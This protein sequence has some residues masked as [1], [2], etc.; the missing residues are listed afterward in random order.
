MNED[1]DGLA[2]LGPLNPTVEFDRIV[3]AA[4]L[5]DES[6]AVN[7][8]ADKRAEMRAGRGPGGRPATVNDRTILI[9]LFLLAAEHN[10][11]HLTR[12]TQMVQ[13]R[14][15]EDSLRYLDLGGFDR[16]SFDKVYHRFARALQ[17]LIEPCD[18]FKGPRGKRLTYAEYETLI[19]SRD[20]EHV[21]RLNA[22]LH[23]IVNDLVMSSVLTYG[24]DVLEGFE[25]NYAVDGTFVKSGGR[26]GTDNRTGKYVATEYDAGRYYRNSVDHTGD[27]IPKVGQK[28]CEE[29]VGLRTHSSGNAQEPTW[30]GYLHAAPDGRSRIRRCLT[31]ARPQRCPR[32]HRTAPLRSPNQSR[33]RRPGLLR[34]RHG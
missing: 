3:A 20:E 34:Q 13:D 32:F 19:A 33:N 8:I 7:K 12:A 16:L 24:S 26:R 2:H 27:D 4:R 22:A 10:P 18:P 15:R 17:R 11:M 23:E 21:D 14:L 29:L 9:L 28:V 30:A 31:G 25:G 6:G 1:F 5:I